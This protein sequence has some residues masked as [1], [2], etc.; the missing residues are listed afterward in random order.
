MNLADQSFDDLRSSVRGSAIRSSEVKV[1][2]STNKAHKETHQHAPVSCL[3]TRGEENLVVPHII[4]ML[5]KEYEKADTLFSALLL[6][7]E[8]LLAQYL[9]VSTSCQAM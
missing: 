9:D 3:K 4:E 5:L 6:L 7:V 1:Q 8:K 2:R